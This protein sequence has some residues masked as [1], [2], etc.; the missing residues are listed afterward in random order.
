[1]SKEKRDANPGAFLGVGVC[2][3]GAGVVFMAALRESGGAGVG[4]G[5]IGVGVV[6][7][8]L[9]LTQRKK[10]ESGESRGNDDDRPPA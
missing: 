6:F 5:L 3:M 4:V 2:F 9:G 1:M 10:L 8:V 7:M